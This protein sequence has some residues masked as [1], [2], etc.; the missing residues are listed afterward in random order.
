MPGSQTLFYAI[1]NNKLEDVKTSLGRAPHLLNTTLG[2]DGRT[3]LMMASL[4]GCEAIVKYLLE[5]GANVLTKTKSGDTAL[6]FAFQ[7][8]NLQVQRLLEAYTPKSV[9]SRDLLKNLKAALKKSGCSLDIL[10]NPVDLTKSNILN[11][12][13]LFLEKK[14]KSDTLDNES[15]VDIYLSL[16]GFLRLNECDS[17][18]TL[19]SHLKAIFNARSLLV[20]GTAF[21]FN[22]DFIADINPLLKSIVQQVWTGE[23]NSNKT[24]INHVL[25]DNALSHF[26]G[27]ETR[28]APHGSDYDPF[29]DGDIPSSLLPNEDKAFIRDEH[30]CIHEPQ[31]IVEILIQNLKARQNCT[32]RYLARK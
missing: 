6:I 28:W 4:F 29:L 1:Q 5:E 15:V 19:K 21:D 24:T 31:K 30:D 18:E 17:I 2:P 13:D 25:F 14:I 3:P 7:S 27:K 23:I 20:K 16:M 8:Q 12:I 32:R 11:A 22:R 26:E 10:S 9:F